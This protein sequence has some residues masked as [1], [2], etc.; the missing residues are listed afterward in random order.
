MLFRSD[1]APGEGEPTTGTDSRG[2][3]SF[4]DSEEGADDRN[5]DGIVD[6]RDG[7][8][9]VGRYSPNGI[10]TVTSAVDSISGSD[11]GFPLVGLPGRGASLLTT[12]KYATLLRWRPDSTVAGLP[13]TPEL[14]NGLFAR[15]LAD[16]PATFTVDDFDPYAAIASTDPAEVAKGIDTI[17]FS[18]VHLADVL[19]VTALLRNLGLDYG[20]EGEIGRAHV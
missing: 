11:L 9:V 1:L 8:V 5:G 7:L 13:V 14:I 19:A 20:N 3:F 12:L 2:A 6:Y 18:Y 15:I 10:G 17:R 16:V 4:G